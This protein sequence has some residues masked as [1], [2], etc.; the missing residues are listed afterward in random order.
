MESR[1]CFA[2][3]GGRRA[4]QASTLDLAGS[5]AARCSTRTSLARRGSARCTGFA[6]V[7]TGDEACRPV[8]A[9]DCFVTGERV[10]YTSAVLPFRAVIGRLGTSSAIVLIFL[11]LPG[12]TPVPVQ[13]G[14]VA[15]A[16]I[17]VNGGDSSTLNILAIGSVGTDGRFVSP[18]RASGFAVNRGDHLTI[19]VIGPGMER[20]TVVGV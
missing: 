8:S 13:V 5:I 17:A 10:G 2:G 12:C 3:S 7:R 6:S 9:G 19:A 16:P 1:S 15:S 18:P 11:S 4:G 20:G 14:Q